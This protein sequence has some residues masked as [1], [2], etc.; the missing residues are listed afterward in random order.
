[1]KKVIGYRA[2]VGDLYLWDEQDEAG[3]RIVE[4]L[5]KSPVVTHSVASELVEEY[6]RGG[7]MSVTARVVKV[8]RRAPSKPAGPVGRNAWLRDIHCQPKQVGACR[9]IA[10][11]SRGPDWVVVEWSY[12]RNRHEAGDVSTLPLAWLDLA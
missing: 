1:M 5:E 9:I 10:L 7:R 8:T 3:S 4:R 2:K 12:D 11:S 6:D